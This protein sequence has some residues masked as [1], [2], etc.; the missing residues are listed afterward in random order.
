MRKKTFFSMEILPPDSGDKLCKTDGAVDH[1]QETG[2]PAAGPETD[3]AGNSSVNA[4]SESVSNGTA[5]TNAAKK[6]NDTAGMTDGGPELNDGLKDNNVEGVSIDL[7]DGVQGGGKDIVLATSTNTSDDPNLEFGERR[8]AKRFRVL[9]TN[10][11]HLG[12]GGKVDR[13]FFGTVEK[14]IPGNVELWRILY[15]D[16]DVDIMSRPKLSA[17]LEYYVA[18]KQLDTSHSHKRIS[19][20][21][22][23]ENAKKRAKNAKPKATPPIKAKKP[24]AKVARPCPVPIWEGAPDEEI[25]GGWPDG[26]SIGV[27]LPLLRCGLDLT[28]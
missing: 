16:G 10:R 7:G 17:A 23:E 11:E 27:P 26:V 5:D 1:E 25:D 3:S 19:Y 9:T 6:Q 15:D 21:G 22:E 4:G 20:E 2:K 13:I 28:C 24:K 18:N 14:L 12:T 8:I